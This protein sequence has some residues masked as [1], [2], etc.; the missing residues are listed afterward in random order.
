ML[1]FGCGPGTAI[2]AAAQVWPDTLRF[3]QGVDSHQAMLDALHYLWEGRH[4]RHHHHHQP[5]SSPARRGGRGGGGR[6]GG[7]GGDG[8]GDIPDE[9]MDEDA[10]RAFFGD[11]FTAAHFAAL[12]DEGTGEIEPEQVRSLLLMAPA[13]GEQG[14]G[15]APPEESRGERNWRRKQEAKE[16]AAIAAAAQGAAQ[17]GKK[18]SEGGVNEDEDEEDEEGGDW[19]GWLRA[20]DEAGF[21]PPPDL[22]VVASRGPLGPVVEAALRRDKERIIEELEDSRRKQPQQ[23]RRRGGR[24][25]SQSQPQRRRPGRFDL[26][27]ATWVLEDLEVSARAAARAR[28]GKGTTIENN[29]N[30]GGDDNAHGGRKKRGR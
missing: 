15:A 4:H 16:A 10:A 11:W 13:A 21:A 7:R 9:P 2:W 26:V 1:D 18:D 24:R 5:S 17:G 25:L 12:A 29:G 22:Q 6:G 3:A 30:D 8:D 27:T 14:G 28:G 20:L 19:L 23:Q